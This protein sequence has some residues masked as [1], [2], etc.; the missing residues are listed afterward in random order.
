MILSDGTIR[1]CHTDSMIRATLR[2][3]LIVVD[4]DSRAAAAEDSSMAAAIVDN[5]RAVADNNMAVEV[6]RVSVVLAV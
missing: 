6:V 4:M 3:C 1:H 5:S 2:C